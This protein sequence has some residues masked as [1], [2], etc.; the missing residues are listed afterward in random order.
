MVTVLSVSSGLYLIFP[1]H[2]DQGKRWSSGSRL[3]RL[4]VAEGRPA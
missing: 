1:S 3:V 4:A 2:C